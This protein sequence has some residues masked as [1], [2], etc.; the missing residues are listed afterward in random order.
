MRSKQYHPLIYKAQLLWLGD[1]QTTLYDA[2]D[3]LDR[4]ALEISKLSSD[5]DISNFTDE[6]QVRKL[7]WSKF[8]FSIPSEVCLL[9]E[10]LEGMVKEMDG[11]FTNELVMLRQEKLQ[12][13]SLVDETN[14]IGRENDKKS[15]L[16]LLLDEDEEREGLDKSVT[17]I[18]IVGMAGVGKTTVA[19]LVY[20]DVRVVDRFD[21]RIWVSVSNEE[22]NVEGVTKSIIQSASG[23]LFPFGLESSQM[24][25]TELLKGKR[26]LIVLDGMWNETPNYWDLLRLPFRVA[27]PGSRVLITTQS[28]T[29][30][31]LV[32]STPVHYMQV[33]TDIDCWKIF[34]QRAF[35]GVN[36]NE[37][38]NLAK[39][40]L[41]IA[42]K[43]KGLPLSARVLGSALRFKHDEIEWDSILKNKMWDIPECE[44][45]I[46]PALKMSFYHLAPN[47]KRCFAY[48]SIFPKDFHFQK[49]SLVHSWVSEGFIQPRGVRLVED[50]GREYFD[51]LHFRSFIQLS[52]L[53]DAGIPVYKIH[54]LT[55]ELAQF[56]SNGVCLSIEEDNMSMLW[57]GYR[58]A[59]HLSLILVDNK[60]ET[61]KVV[62]RCGHLR[63]F[64][65]FS[66]PVLQI[67][68]EFF[69]NL[70]YIRVLNLSFANINELPESVRALKH[71]RQLDISNTSIESLPEE[72]TDLHGIEILKF[73]NCVRLLELPK[74]LKKL[75]NLR[76]LELGIYLFRIRFM[77]LELGKLINLQTLSEFIV[78]KETGRRINE[79]E[80]MNFLHGSLRITHIEN[81]TDMTEARTAKLELKTHLDD[82]Q[83]Q[84]NM[85][86][87]S[88]TAQQVLTGLEPHN[89]VKRVTIK[90]YEGVMFPSWLGNPKFCCL[91]LIHLQNCHNCKLLPT[92]GKLPM[93]KYLV[94]E[95][96][97]DLVALEFE[98][99]SFLTLQSLKIQYM[100]N[101]LNWTGL[102][103]NVMP[104]LSQLSVMACPSLSFLPPLDSLASLESLTIRNCKKIKSLPALPNSL[105]SLSIVESSILIERC[106]VGDGEDWGKIC[107]IPKVVFD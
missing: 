22:D 54:N 1:L 36:P 5:D 49:D 68:C 99:P 3:V 43:C 16:R 39:I 26:F 33:L 79:L 97:S 46:L 90:G 55:H 60:P 29:V 102:M 23:E 52:K 40:G 85:F 12:T 76:H 61:F 78:G 34:Q 103:P 107:S 89:R 41:K 17:T 59:R 57:P 81:V 24:K 101:L 63:T 92:F 104:N 100:E 45:Q 62:Q 67:P 28:I 72:I 47:L 80:E 35:M 14:V 9:Q 32:S 37:H 13:S 6:Q 105:K 74:K 77:P 8:E 71:L 95:H 2:D 15:I 64:I 70:T 31:R 44:D 91:E 93:L 21:L 73:N 10:R 65:L 19:Q 82:L 25:L 56:V 106:K 11:F 98:V 18:A 4:I 69:E 84:W 94:I 48:C 20:N 96:L 88:Q 27:T 87:D 42:Q 83:L 7:I 50:I 58:N 53:D 86:Q 66:K 30:S 75:K 38:Q 51:I